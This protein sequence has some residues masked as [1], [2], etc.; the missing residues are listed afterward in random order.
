MDDA[1]GKVKIGLVIYALGDLLSVHK[2]LP[3]SRLA[4]M[5]RIRISK[6]SAGG[7]ACAR[8]SGLEIL[9]TYLYAKV[10]RDVC[11]DYRVLDFRKLLEE[12][13][14]GKNRLG[15]SRAKVR[16][17]FR[18]EALMNEILHAALKKA[19]VATR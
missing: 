15:L 6:G 5:A 14:S 4:S 3:N 1:T 17:A 12:L 2:T 18:L 9:P 7:E 19:E 16:E 8:V 11:R 13:H 10:E